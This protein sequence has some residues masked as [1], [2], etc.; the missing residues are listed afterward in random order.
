MENNQET[1][2]AEP[3]LA[4][5]EIRVRFAQLDKVDPILVAI[6]AIVKAVGPK[7]CG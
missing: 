2:P 7:S 1:P 4:V 5:L 3:S 6:A